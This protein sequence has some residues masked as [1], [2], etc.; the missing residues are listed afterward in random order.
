GPTDLI[1]YDNGH[2][3]LTIPPAG[4][5]NAGDGL[6]IGYK[7]G[8]CIKYYT[9][10]ILVL[11]G[12][13][14]VNKCD[15]RFLFAEYVLPTND[16]LD[17]HLVYCDACGSVSPYCADCCDNLGCIKENCDTQPV[18]A[19][20]T[21]VCLLNGIPVDPLPNG[22]CPSECAEGII[23]PICSTCVSGA[24]VPAPVCTAPFILNT[25]TCLCECPPGAKF[26]VLD[27][28]NPCITPTNCNIPGQSC[29]PCFNCVEGVCTPIPCSG[30][31]GMINNPIGDGTVDHPCCIDNP[32]PN[33]ITS[34][35]VNKYCTDVLPRRANVSADATNYRIKFTQIQLNYLPFYSQVDCEYE[36]LQAITQT[37]NLIGSVTYEINYTNYVLDWVPVVPSGTTLIIPQSAGNGFLIK[38]SWKGREVIY[39]FI[40]EE[41]FNGSADQLILGEYPIQV[42]KVKDLTCGNV[43]GLSGDC[44]TTYSWEFTQAELSAAGQF[45]TDNPI[46][47][48]PTGLDAEVCVNVTTQSN[49]V[50]CEETQICEDVDECQGACGCDPCN[51]GGTLFSTI[52]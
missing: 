48:S 42:R 35:E 23:I 19:N 41:G 26:S 15:D 43:Y 46:V 7:I 40:F 37:N 14:S 8:N 33:C 34:L 12:V 28:L 1:Y 16:P 24:I 39:E 22:C 27:P 50:I 45:I 32:C 11:P 5:T 6:I 13:P 51:G 38:C 44:Q 30:V 31:P 36:A 2:I 10:H 29:D 18:C 25:N 49:G 9:F 3:A 52:E 20:G 4:I 17:E 21:C 47:V